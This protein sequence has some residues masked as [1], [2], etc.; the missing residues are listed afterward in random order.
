M[1]LSVIAFGEWDLAGPSIAEGKPAHL[2]ELLTEISKTHVTFKLNLN[3][4]TI[5]RS[6]II[7]TSYTVLVQLLGET[8]SSI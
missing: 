4:L 3:I 8:L 2:S 6:Y 5:Q 7:Y 1:C